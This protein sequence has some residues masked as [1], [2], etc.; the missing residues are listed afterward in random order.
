MLYTFALLRSPLKVTAAD[1]DAFAH[2][3]GGTAAEL[4]LDPQR[5]TRT[6]TLD[7]NDPSLSFLRFPRSIVQLPLLMD[8]AE[9]Y[10]SYSLKADGAVKLHSPASTKAESLLDE[11]L[12]EHPARLDCIPYRQYRAALLRSAVIDET[13]LS[14]EDLAE[15]RL[16]GEDFSQIGGSLLQG[17]NYH[18]YC[19]NPECSGFGTQVTSSLA[20][21]AREPAPGISLGFLPNDPAVEFSLCQSCHSISGTVIVD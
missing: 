13:F 14:E 9:G 1:G 10:I 6:L 4:G 15:V 7:L 21:I 3:F 16:L 11:S 18:P 17:S 8:F 2:Y 20:S 5:Y 12:E 19:S